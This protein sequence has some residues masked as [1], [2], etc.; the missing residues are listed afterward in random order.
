MD[1]VRFAI[2]GSRLGNRPNPVGEVELFPRE[3][4]DFLASLPGKR[5]K[6]DNSSVWA[7]HLTSGKQDLGEL[8]VAE[9]SVSS[10]LLRRQGYAFRWRLVQDRSTHAP[11]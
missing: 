8:G 6:L 9:H 10:P 1:D 5:Q 2:F 3:A 7:T 4:G 11:A